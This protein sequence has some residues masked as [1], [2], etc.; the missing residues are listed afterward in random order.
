MKLF[1]I[2][3]LIKKIIQSISKIATQRIYKKKY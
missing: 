2:V 3:H 1:H